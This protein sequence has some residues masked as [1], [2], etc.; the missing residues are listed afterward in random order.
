MKRLPAQKCHTIERRQRKKRTVIGKSHMNI[1]EPRHNA[2]FLDPADAL[3][4]IQIRII[5]HISSRRTICPNENERCHN[6]A[7]RPAALFDASSKHLPCRFSPHDCRRCAKN[8]QYSV[9]KHSDSAKQAENLRI[10]SRTDQA[11]KQY[12]NA[13]IHFPSE[14]PSD[15]S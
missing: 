2:I 4:M 3:R 5:M 9:R 14:P 15:E 11:V 1:A 13:V 10:Y 8:S 7:M 12:F 6:Q